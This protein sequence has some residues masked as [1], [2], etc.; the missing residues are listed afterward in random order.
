MLCIL[1]D[2]TERLADRTQTVSW[3]LAL[4][5]SFLFR[6]LCAEWPCL[7]LLQANLGVRI[8]RSL[9]EAAFLLSCLRPLWIRVHA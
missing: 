6:C 1:R 7:V 8:L 2:R 3:D 5:P 9:H 4:A